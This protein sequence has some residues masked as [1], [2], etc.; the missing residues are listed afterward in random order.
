M[1]SCSVSMPLENLHLDNYVAA[2]DF[3][4]S[5]CSLAFSVKGGGVEN[6]A[7]SENL[8]RVP[9]AILIKKNENGS[10]SVASIGFIAQG[11]YKTLPPAQLAKRI[12]FECFK[13]QLRDER[14]SR[15]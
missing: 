1:A 3:G 2:I 12:Y 8:E 11:M 15:P 9:T 5:C 14:V 6:L 4:T 10:V 7:L 13:M